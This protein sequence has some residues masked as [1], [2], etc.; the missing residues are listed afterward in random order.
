MRA[1]AAVLLSALLLPAASAPAA[2]E[3]ASAATEPAPQDAPTPI[4]PLTLATAEEL[5]ALN[6]LAQSPMWP[7]RALGVMR[8]ERHDCDASAGRLLAFTG[9][10]SWRVRA[11]AYAC[12]ARRGVA[13]EPER[14]GAERDPRVM[15][16]IL[17]CRYEVPVAAV[18]ACLRPLEKSQDPAE[19]MLALELLAAQD[20]ADDKAVRERLEELLTRV[21]LRMDRAEGGALSARLAAV[22]K[23]GDSG[24]N[25][26]WRE[27]LRKNKRDPGYRPAALVDARPSG[28]RL[29]STNKVAALDPVR[30]V[31]FRAYLSTIGDRPMDLAILID[32]TASMSGE[33]AEAQ[34]TIDQLCDFL[35]S[36]TSGVRLGIVGYRDKTD[37]WETKAWDF[38]ANADEARKNLWSLSAM[39]GG[40]APESVHAAMKLALT[41]F[42]WLPDAPQQL[43]QPIRACVL[44]GDAPPHAGE[45]KLC[46]DLAKRAAARGVRC[47]G[48]IARDSE[49]N[50][51]DES[52][53]EEP[54]SAPPAT[55]PDAPPAQAPDAPPGSRPT[56]APPRAPVPEVAKPERMSYTRFPEISEA[57][58]GRAEILRD[59]DSLAAQIAELTIADKY[60][61]EFAEFFAAFRVLCR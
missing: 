5:A 23:G 12:L 13:I 49:D 14:L 47:Y 2:A 9:D 7:L 27:W 15:R 60:R 20:R 8:L 51:K 38:T 58:G 17:R 50:L 46:M 30:F 40:D 61:E 48:I 33:L 29:S 21:I 56:V 55:D 25:Y 34:A 32:C 16:T 24:R 39:G 57:G 6:G 18:E 11:Y 41:R 28:I 10:P 4:L 1:A 26:R 59:K 42:N 44:V 43:P 36:I 54:E 31:A 22:T 53:Q 37:E 35:G 19:A 3:A 52:Q 45:T